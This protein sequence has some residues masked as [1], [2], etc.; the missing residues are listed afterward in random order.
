[1][2][3]V[4]ILS[5]SDTHLVSFERKT[6]TIPVKSVLS[7]VFYT[8]GILVVVNSVGQFD[9]QRSTVLRGQNLA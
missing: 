7:I 2:Q 9:P 3:S 8:I 4:M 5:S 6:I 1:M